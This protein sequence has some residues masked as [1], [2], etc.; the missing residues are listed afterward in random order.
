MS[1]PV[2]L[3]ALGV[4][5]LIRE[6]EAKADESLMV[7]L[8]LM[9]QI[10]RVRQTERMPSP[11]VAQDGIIRL[12]RSIQSAVDAQNDLF[13]THDALTKAQHQ[14]WADLPH[15]DTPPSGLEVRP[16]QEAA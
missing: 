15:D 4:R 10:L 7:K 11:H 5:N 9:K 8:E 14:V 2:P 13:R 12:A 6:A 1:Q 3:A 16:R